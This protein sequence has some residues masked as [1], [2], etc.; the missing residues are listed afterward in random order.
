MAK[1]FSLDFAAI[2][3]VDTEFNKRCFDLLCRAYIEARYNKDFTVTREEY[4]YMLQRVG[5]LRDLTERVCRER[6]DY[7]DEMIAQEEEM[8]L[9]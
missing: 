8:Q 3:P 7:Y 1:G 4:E 6:F 9:K 2:F 5:M